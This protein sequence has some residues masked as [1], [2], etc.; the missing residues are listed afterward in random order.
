MAEE[1]LVFGDEKS[2]NAVKKNEQRDA[3]LSACDSIFEEFGHGLEPGEIGRIMFISAAAYY[4]NSDV[5]NIYEFSKGARG[6][7]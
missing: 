7:I 3:L 5:I 6:G 1:K 4:F 2:I